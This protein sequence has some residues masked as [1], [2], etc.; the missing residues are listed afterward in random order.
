MTHQPAD[1]DRPLSNSERLKIDYRNV[2]QCL[3]RDMKAF[4][5]PG[6]QSGIAELSV[7]LEAPEKLLRNQFKPDEFDHAPPLHRFLQ[8]VEALHSRATV[9]A[10]A[11]LAECVT[12][13]RSP[14]AAEVGA[15]AGQAEAFAALVPLVERELRAT[16]A[17]LQAG[18]T[19]GSV[20]RDQARDALYNVVA[21]AAHLLTRIE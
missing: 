19:L 5:T 9:Q 11:S 21:Y 1:A 13:P 10:I 2:M 6:V 12:V 14:K 8:V 15:P 20:E 17:R 16:N 7:T 3:Y 4:C 18:K